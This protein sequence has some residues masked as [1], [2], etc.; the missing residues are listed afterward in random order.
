MDNT[1]HETEAQKTRNEQIGGMAGMGAGM[2]AGARVG[3]AVIPI[4]V[5]GTFAGAM[6]GGMLGSEIGK[7]VGAATLSGFNAFLDTLTTPPP[8]HEDDQP[9]SA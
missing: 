1:E 6:L 9:Q 2:L 4:P 5:L 7:R 3:S 8:K